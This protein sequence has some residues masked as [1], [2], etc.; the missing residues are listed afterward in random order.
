MGLRDALKR[1]NAE[2][3]V[4]VERSHLRAGDDVRLRVTIG[5]ELD[6]KVQ[7]ARAGIRCTHRYLVRERDHSDHDR[8]DHDELWR[9]ITL[10]EE[11]AS[12]AAQPGTGDVTCHVPH[13]S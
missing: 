5:G 1:N 11:I 9:S 4:E 3:A 2:I 12:I 7:G 13:G 10:H 8:T 6:D